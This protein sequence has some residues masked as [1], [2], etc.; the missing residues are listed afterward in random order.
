M[1]SS[2]PDL[3]STRRDHPNH[4]REFLCVLLLLMVLLAVLF[5]PSFSPGMVVFAND[6]SLGMLQAYASQFFSGF[7]GVWFDLHGLGRAMPAS[8]P[9][10]TQVFYLLLASPWSGPE[11]AVYFAKFYAP[12]AL[13]FL[14]LCAWVLFRALKLRPAVCAVAAVAA[15]LH[16]DP[17]SNACWGLPPWAICHGLVFLALA[18]VVTACGRHAIIKLLLAGAATALGITEAYD[19]GALFSLVIAAFTVFACLTQE[20]WRARVLAKSGLNV[21]LV[22]GFALLVAAST[23]VTLIGTEVK[24]V[25]G[26]GQDAESKAE[27]WNVAI[28][29]SLPKQETLRILI[30]GLYGYLPDTPNGGFYWGGVG[31]P[32]ESG[33]GEYAGV[34]VVL[35]AAWA[36]V[37]SFRR[38]GSPYDTTQRRHIW[39]WSGTALIMLLLAYGK[40]APFYRL[41]YLLPYA[42]TIRNPIKFMQPFSVAIGI[43][44]AFGLEGFARIYL[45]SVVGAAKPAKGAA[46]SWWASQP[47]F[48]RG[49][50][51]GLAGFMG[52]SGLA[53]MMYAQAG[54]G[55]AQH[56]QNVLACDES[57]ARSV[58]E[59]SQREVGW[60]VGY[61]ALSG[62][63][64]FAIAKGWLGRNQ[65]WLAWV[66]L[67]VLVGA[68]LARANAPWIIHFDYRYRYAV[69]PVL[70]RFRQ[71][72]FELRVQCPPFR[73]AFQLTGPAGQALGMLEAV[74]GEWIQ[75]GMPMN[76][77]Q[78]LD[79][80]QDPRPAEDAQMYR[81]VF[82]SQPALWPRLWEL[83]GTRYLLG[84]SGGF[85]GSLNTQLDPGA[86]RL[87]LD[88][89]FALEP[90]PEAPLPAG[91]GMDYTGRIQPDGP[92]AII[93]FTGALPR[94]RLYSQ[95]Q[96]ETNRTN[97]LLRISEPAFDPQR[98]VVV[99][100]EMPATSAAT[101]PPP[102]TVEIVSYASKRVQL[103]ARAE[104]T[105][106][107]LLNDKYDPD[108]TV[109]V[110]G[111]PRP[112]LRCNFLMR[113]VLLSPGPHQ[114]EFRYEARTPALW[115]TLAALGLSGV[116]LG[117]VV[118]SPG[119]KAR[120]S[121][122]NP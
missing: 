90:K 70:E 17:F 30:P 119:G 55:M 50:F 87:K 3:S 2:G 74:Y 53:F 39:F 29:Y 24:G 47:G 111:Q 21:A 114:V 110:D 15:A 46:R 33:S 31:G 56:L 8:A 81:S 102:G 64:L 71:K 32:R 120:T 117:I 100:E 36:V 73:R 27:R 66:C 48:D 88:S 80:I 76:R 115:I 59:F 67:G 51:L 7:L 95:W 57:L 45:G 116:M 60:Y 4:G 106:V 28:H 79:I 121:P 40:H 61:L 113:G 92:Y 68:D 14:G 20:P 84:L 112:L 104:T 107:L 65:A 9:N 91:R 52:L 96:I 26:M 41:F 49:C 85:I 72:P 101:N 13:V 6:F 58:F 97:A 69:N 63:L 103:A 86:N 12:L 35:L 105:A 10:V 42:S 23:L 77:I 122:A 94:A 11:G 118:F 22:A 109:R 99:G 75:H 16:T 82:Y 37:Q 43:L 25:V 1:R 83:T 93:E 78:T 89:A 18:A 44:F 98:T 108:W 62:G 34:L 54:T 19:T 38:T 5:S